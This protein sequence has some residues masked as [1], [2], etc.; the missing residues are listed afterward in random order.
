[1][2]QIR[3]SLMKYVGVLSVLIMACLAWPSAHAEA[4]YGPGTYAVP[5]QLP[6]GV[7]TASVDQNDFGRACSFSTWTSDWK[8]LTGDS[9]SPTKTLVAVIQPPLV[10]N[11][12][13]HGCTPWTKV[14]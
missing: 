5:A 7:Y 11:F 13:T 4:T 8:F 12:I 6:Y 14:Q 3:A 10:A 9:G 2:R 1:M